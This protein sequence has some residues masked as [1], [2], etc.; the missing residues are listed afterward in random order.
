MGSDQVGDQ[1]LQLPLGGS[2]QQEVPW[3]CP[4]THEA[5]ALKKLPAIFKI[6]YLSSF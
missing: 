4:T 6:Y 3:L 1:G 5:G 2:G